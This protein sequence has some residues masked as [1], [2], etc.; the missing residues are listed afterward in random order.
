[1]ESASAAL[2][3]RRQS[4]PDMPVVI[5]APEPVAPTPPKEKTVTA[6][7]RRLPD[8]AQTEIIEE[9]ALITI[10]IP[11]LTSGPATQEA[12]AQK[13]Q[14][15]KSGSDVFDQSFSPSSGDQNLPH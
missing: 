13:P 5:D 15:S 2:I 3:L 8:N 7:P 10:T 12:P 4:V 6:P 14:K 9:P 1:M 11:I